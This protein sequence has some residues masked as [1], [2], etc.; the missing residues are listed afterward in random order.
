MHLLLGIIF[1]FFFFVN[2]MTCL[3]Y[4]RIRIREG[5][6]CDGPLYICVC[7]CVCVCDAVLW[8]TIH[9]GTSVKFLFYSYTE[10]LSGYLKF[11]DDTLKH[12][13]DMADYIKLTFRISL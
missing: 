2:F 7:V 11:C 10:A 5:R 8:K 4:L 13:K 6:I 9:F 12:S 1:F 3:D